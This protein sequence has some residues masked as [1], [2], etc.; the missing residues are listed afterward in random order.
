MVSLN[1]PTGIWR[2]LYRV[3]HLTMLL[4]G[5][6]S[7]PGSNINTTLVNM[8]A[9]MSLFR[10][11]QG[12]HTPLFPSQETEIAIPWFVQANIL[13]CQQVWSAA[14]ATTPQST[15][16]SKKNYWLLSLSCPW[17]SAR[18]EGVALVKRPAPQ[19]QIQE[20]GTHR[21]LCTVNE[22]IINP[23]VVWLRHPPVLKVSPLF[24]VSLIKPVSSGPLCPPVEPPQPSQVVDVAS[25]LTVGE[26]LDV[27]WQSWSF[28]YLVY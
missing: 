12:F 27:L 10:V 3:L 19:S 16:W 1:V 4:P 8:S 2:L 15:A 6:S 20:V 24:H 26:I 11:A 14:R 21:P 28:Q 9:G 17:I 7:S 22:K 5:V 13:H 23:S 18:W 25:A